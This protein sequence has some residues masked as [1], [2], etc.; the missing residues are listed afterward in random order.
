MSDVIFDMGNPP[1]TDYEKTVEFLKQ[2][3]LRLYD[4]WVGRSFICDENLVLNGFRMMPIL[5]MSGL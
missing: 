3:I 1:E 5:N 4:E 2:A